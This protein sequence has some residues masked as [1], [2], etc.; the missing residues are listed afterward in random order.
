[1]AGRLHNK[2]AL[3]VGGTSGIGLAAAGRF[4]DE[5]AQV[6]VAGHVADMGAAAERH[7]Q[8]RGVVCFRLCDATL[9]EQVAKLFTDSVAFL[10]RLDILLHTMG[11][12]GRTL[13]DGPL[14][15]CTDQGWSATLALNLSSVF[16]TN[17]QAIRWF[18]DHGQPGV[19]L[20]TGSVLAVS[21]SPEH[22]DTCAYT[23]A[24]GGIIN[25]SRLAAARYAA[26]GIRVN[27]LAP[28]LI[29]TPMAQRAVQ[30]T[31]IAEFLR[32]KQPLF[33]GPGTPEDCAAAAVFLCSDEAR[34]ITGL[35]LPV[36]GGW[37]VI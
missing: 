21:P 30:D 13:G 4:L 22:F 6:V 3:I 9:P 36:D 16:L 14:H 28:G 19:V 15:A 11:G 2:R 26:N 18:L 17:R 27:V 25:L 37:S 29:D 23:A 34:G 7:L 5:G 35:V 24:K 12:S 1:M 10:G 31:M 8:V 20:N 32:A 33:G